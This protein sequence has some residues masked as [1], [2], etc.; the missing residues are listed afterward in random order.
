MKNAVVLFITISF[1]ALISSCVFLDSVEGNGNVTEQTRDL[2]DFE[3][4]SVTQGLNVYVTQGTPAKVI[5]KA[6]ENLHEIIETSVVDGTLKVTSNKTIR[7]AKSNKVYVT[8]AK[9]EIL[10]STAGSNIYSEDTLRFQRL[11]IKSTA[12]S[13]VKLTIDSNEL[14]ASATAGSNIFLDGNT[15]TG[16][17]KAS[18]GSNVKA[19]NLLIENCTAKA[20]S[21]S[22]IW[23]NRP[24]SLDARASSGANIWYSGD[25]ANLNI[26][27]SSGGNVIK[28]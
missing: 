13:N 21:G 3:K 16:T 20:N 11:E 23:T 4:I 19:G 1:L 22:N 24:K 12:G 15:K 6:D 18:A 14:E 9:I 26:E 28:N 17:F 27:K 8:V 10:K 2:G 25:P 7:K 5:V